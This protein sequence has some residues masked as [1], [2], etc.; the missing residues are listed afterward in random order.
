MTRAILN[1][2]LRLINTEARKSEKDA[3]D[4]IVSHIRGNVEAGFQ[5]FLTTLSC[6]LESY[7]LLGMSKQIKRF[8]T[9]QSRKRYVKVTGE[10]AGTVWHEV[11]G[12]GYTHYFE[13]GTC[14]IPNTDEVERSPDFMLLV[15]KA[16]CGG[17]MDD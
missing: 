2:C 5:E 1:E 10:N 4:Y 7:E 17:V 6:L 14:S 9:K 16:P 11:A 13:D 15:E 12:Q 8:K 3:I